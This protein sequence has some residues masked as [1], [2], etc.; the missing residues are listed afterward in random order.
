MIR[1]RQWLPFSHSLGFAIA[2]NVGAGPFFYPRNELRNLWM[3][4]QRLP[5]VEVPGKFPL[6]QCGV[7]FLVA[8]LVQQVFVF[9]AH[10]FWNQVVF[11][12]GDAHFHGAATQRAD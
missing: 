6:C 5:V 12:R 11:V 8:N 3:R 1:Q 9:S 2:V 4:L 7:Y 10:A